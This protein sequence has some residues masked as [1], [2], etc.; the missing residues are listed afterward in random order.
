MT[1][2]LSPALSED[3]EEQAA[4]W[5]ARLRS[6]PLPA[7]QRAELQAWLATAAHRDLLDDYCE[8]SADFD[9]ALRR[10]QLRVAA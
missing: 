6:G 7:E 1:T 3:L 4:L 2:Q 10:A 8:T 5:T 9:A